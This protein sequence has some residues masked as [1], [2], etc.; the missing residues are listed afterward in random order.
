MITDTDNIIDDVIEE[1]RFHP[2]IFFLGILAGVIISIFMSFI[3]MKKHRI[4]DDLLLDYIN[5]RPYLFTD[6]EDIQKLINR[7]QIA[8]KITGVANVELILHQKDLYS[9]LIANNFPSQEVKNLIDVVREEFDFRNL[10]SGQ[11]FLLE[12]DFEVTLQP[13]AEHDNIMP[14]IY[15]KIEKRSIRFLKFKDQKNIKYSV[16][17]NKV[18]NE[19][20]I[21]VSKPTFYRKTRV[22]SGSV[23]TN[24]FTDVLGYNVKL[25]TL[26]KILN[27]YAFVIDFQR[28]IR[29]G[30][31]FSLVLDSLY[32]DDGEVKDEKILMATLTL[33]GKK[34]EIFNFNDDFYDRSGSSI[35][36]SLL[37]SPVDG[38]RISS[39]FSLS[40]KHPILG[41][42]RAHLGIDFA[43][44]IGTPI[45][46]AG[47]GVVSHVGWKGGY[48]K[49]VTIKHN[50][51]FTTNYAHL[52]KFNVKAGQRIRQRQIIGYVGMTGLASGPHLHY[53]I[54]RNNVHI[55]PKSVK[56]VS[57]RKI[58]RKYLDKFNEYK[59]YI[60][61]I[62]RN[63]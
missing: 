29:K 2:R 27:E 19:Y 16:T 28:D 51:E 3:Y 18:N 63:Q 17:K 53:E 39:G 61:K 54:L 44:P 50:K 8:D 20:N 23:S 13:I 56:S 41:Y 12:Y 32:D 9:L 14:P 4:S 62:V 48:G 40:R 22:V 46:A 57:S 31:K 60:D 7:D 10:K 15:E 35:K 5:N 24:L 36:K 47:D 21:I 49:L 38:A 1:V 59:D 30:D 42:S 58:D 33:K 55:N 11:K 43:V 25:N 45:Y 52:S 26:Y 37:K 6:A 34:Y